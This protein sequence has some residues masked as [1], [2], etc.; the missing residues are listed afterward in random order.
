MASPAS[1]S[2]TTAR[3]A[4]STTT[5]TT[6]ESPYGAPHHREPPTSSPPPSPH[7][8]SNPAL[9]TRD[10]LQPARHLPRHNGSGR[11]RLDRDFR[12]PPGRLPDRRPQTARRHTRPQAAGTPCAAHLPVDQPRLAA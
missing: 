9:R 1:S 12:N 10:L 7:D 2:V 5:T 3:C 4:T 11:I 8:S 6:T